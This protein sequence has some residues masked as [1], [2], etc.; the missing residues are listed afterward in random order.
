MTPALF[1]SVV[2][3]GAV[4]RGRK[5]LSTFAPVSYGMPLEQLEQIQ[6]V[7]AGPPGTPG[8]ARKLGAAA[9]RGPR[10]KARPRL[11]SARATAWG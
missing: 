4:E 6:A 5:L 11:R 3:A 2:L 1:V 9:G 7:A 10:R 8:R